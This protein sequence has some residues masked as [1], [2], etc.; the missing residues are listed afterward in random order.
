MTR[1]T[2]E[3]L[4]A[5]KI[6]VDAGNLTVLTACKQLNISKPTYYSRLAK[7]QDKV[8][9]AK[10]TSD[11]LNQ[12]LPLTVE[13]LDKEAKELLDRLKTMFSDGGYDPERHDKLD[14]LKE[15]RQTITSYRSALQTAVNYF[16]N[17][18]VNVD[19]I[20]VEVR[21]TLMEEDAKQLWIPAL[22]KIVGEKQT[23]EIVKKV[24]VEY[25]REKERWRNL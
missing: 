19:N 13:R 10:E 17:R 22:L 20:T 1:V 6:E 25:E 9:K 15:I 11:K 16:D 18:S 2:D 21:E 24:E 8:M 5:K 3:Q 14:V 23:R 12:T 4:I 7:I